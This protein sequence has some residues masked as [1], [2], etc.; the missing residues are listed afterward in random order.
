M[1]DDGT[2]W[3]SALRWVCLPTY[4]QQIQ[5]VSRTVTQLLS[6]VLLSAEPAVSEALEIVNP[7][8]CA[9]GGSKSRIR[10]RSSHGKESGAGWWHSESQRGAKG[11]WQM[12]GAL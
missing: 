2:C 10:S 4:R 7:S 5:S 1:L 11:N 3:I 9:G 6:E 12:R 8:V